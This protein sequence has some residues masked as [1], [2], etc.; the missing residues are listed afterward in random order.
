MDIYSISGQESNLLRSRW[1]AATCTFRNMNKFL[2]FLLGKISRV[3]LRRN[4]HIHY[5]EFFYMVCF[6]YESCLYAYWF[7]HSSCVCHFWFFGFNPTL[8][9]FR[10]FAVSA[11]FFFSK[12]QVSFC[13]LW[14]NFMAIFNTSSGVSVSK[15]SV[16]WNIE[17]RILDIKNLNLI[18][19]PRLG[20]Q[21][22]P[23]C[24]CI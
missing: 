21:F 14:K 17:F 16:Y 12:I 10:A 7:L 23:G 3:N 22:V 6:L 4:D 19:L 8:D 2:P 9:F 18:H 20:N 1:L 24:F 13:Y 11:A 5:M 15:A